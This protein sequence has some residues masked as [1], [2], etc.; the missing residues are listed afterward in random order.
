[1]GTHGTAAAQAW[2]PTSA[3]ACA[4]RT[5]YAGAAH[6]GQHADDDRVNVRAS[7]GILL[8]AWALALMLPAGVGAATAQADPAS[9]VGQKYPLGPRMEA[10]ADP[11]QSAPPTSADDRRPWL[12]PLTIWGGA[13]A[14]FAALALVA[15]LVLL[16]RGLGNGTRPLVSWRSLV[17]GLAERTPPLPNRI[18]VVALACGSSIVLAYVIVVL[19]G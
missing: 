7:R 5:S 10:P 4:T 11:E 2:S 1:M 14:L 12:T 16:R 6:A 19:P 18:V 9:E 17:A 3:S 15:A 13:I 8:L